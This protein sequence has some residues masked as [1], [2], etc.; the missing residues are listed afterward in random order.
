MADNEGSQRQVTATVVVA[1]SGSPA[2]GLVIKTDGS[3][4]PCPASWTAE[5]AAVLG[6]AV[7]RVIA[8]LN[9]PDP[10]IVTG[11]AQIGVTA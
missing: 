8:T 4:T 1:L 5:Y 2:S 7:D 6:A 3:V 9:T 10:P 11:K